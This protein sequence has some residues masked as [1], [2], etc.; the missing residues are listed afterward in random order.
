M[1]MKKRWFLF[2]ISIPIAILFNYFVTIKLL[3]YINF[4]PESGYI[5][6]LIL[7]I[8]AWYEM[9]VFFFD[10]WNKKDKIIVFTMYYF[11]FLVVF[12]L[13]PEQNSR[14]FQL[15]PFALSSSIQSSHDM[16][17][18]IFNV[19]LFIPLYMLHSF[20]IQEK[21]WNL[22]FCLSIA[23]LIEV[24]QVITLRGIFDVTDIFYYVIGI[25]MGY[26]VSKFIDRLKVGTKAE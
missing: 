16:V 22:L 15:N 5:I 7:Q 17:I 10:Q 13:R 8:L 24:L 3:D 20:F 4:F 12:F 23:F 18:T 25:L 2:L 21:K 1:N 26:V 9:G 6:S 14:I 11:I 19:I